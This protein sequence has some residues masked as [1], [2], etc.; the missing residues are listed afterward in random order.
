MPTSTPLSKHSLKRRVQVKESRSSS[1]KRRHSLT[2]SALEE[3]ITSLWQWPPRETSS[4]T[5]LPPDPFNLVLTLSSTLKLI[6]SKSLMTMALLVELWTW[7]NTSKPYIKTYLGHPQTTLRT[8]S[9]DIKQTIAN[10][11]WWRTTST[12]VAPLSSK[13]TLK[14]FRQ[15]RP[16]LTTQWPNHPQEPLLF[17]TT[18]ALLNIRAWMCSM[19]A[20][21]QSRVLASSLQTPQLP[22]SGSNLNLFDVAF[23]AT[24]KK[25][26]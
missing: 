5:P 2:T 1:R 26:W 10:K 24:R 7:R 18:Q 14:I 22:S 17:S 21:R 12:S 9:W 25:W 20:P 3:A 16:S 11:S 19:E 6:T 15:R 13:K 23:L 4:L 8:L